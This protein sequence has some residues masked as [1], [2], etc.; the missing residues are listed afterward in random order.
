MSAFFLSTCSLKKW[1]DQIR[2][3]D[4]YELLNNR[5]LQI[6]MLKWIGEEGPYDFDLAETEVSSVHS[7]D[8]A[9]RQKIAETYG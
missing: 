7:T 6:E 8:V 4:T 2:L 3:Y 9:K 5:Q 1:P